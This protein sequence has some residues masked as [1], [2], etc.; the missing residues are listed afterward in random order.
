M[1]IYI[2]ISLIL[3]FFLSYKNYL[4]IKK[5]FDVL[6]INSPEELPYNNE[7]DFI[8]KS[9]DRKLEELKK[10]KQLNKD[11]TLK[12]NEINTL[13]NKNTPM[14]K[15]SLLN[16]LADGKAESMLEFD[17]YLRLYDIRF[18][19]PLF[20][21]MIFN[22][23]HMENVER[24][25]EILEMSRYIADTVIEII[26]EGNRKYQVFEYRNENLAIISN[27]KSEISDDEA[28]SEMIDIASKVIGLLEEKTG[29]TSSAGIGNLYGDLYQI[30]NS[31]KDAF[32]AL[33]YRIIRGDSSVICY[34]EIITRDREYYYPIEHELQLINS[35]KAGDI[36]KCELLLSRIFK[37]NFENR[38]LPINLVKCLFFD[39]MST[40]IKSLDSVSIH[41]TQIFG[42]KY[43]P[44]EKI[45]SCETTGEMHEEIMVIYN[46]ICQFINANTRDKKNPLCE[47]I[48]AYVEENFTDQNLSQTDISLH[49]EITS[50]YLSRLFK[51]STGQNMVDYING[52]RIKKAKEL[53]ATTML[54]SNRIAEKVGCTNDKN[55]IRI[56]KQI[57]GITPGKYRDYINLTK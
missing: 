33:E 2:L 50:S 31:C 40:A 6:F 27:F 8:Q 12:N 54:T 21:I 42:D 17:N 15:N 26:S 35:V 9:V 48:I 57:E 14:I 41:Y 19:F 32:K 56:F 46:G 11:I 10:L 30:H 43:E 55:L 51:Q 24:L 38:K 4:P 52:L 37:E 25:S 18:P 49:F 45:T 34:D 1:L 23:S 3:A 13:R 16:R 5:I 53:L 29:I 44:L 7:L 36:D 39:I 28:K 47:K 20:S 22:I